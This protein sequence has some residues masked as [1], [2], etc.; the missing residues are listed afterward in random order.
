MR[1]ITFFSNNHIRIYLKNDFIYLVY[2]NK[3]YSRLFDKSSRTSH[4]PLR[5]RKHDRWKQTC[6]NADC[7][8][9]P[10]F[11]SFFFFNSPVLNLYNNISRL[12]YC[13]SWAPRS[14]NLFPCW[15]LR[16]ETN[17]LFFI[18]QTPP[19]HSLR[20]N[21]S[22]FYEYQTNCTYFIVGLVTH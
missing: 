7:Q 5:R 10:S 16:S 11:F 3:N 6:M 8:I 9:Y 19:V 1:T 20:N 18:Y 2:R 13:S 15:V 4:I 14:F 17:S 12:P 22:L 21:S